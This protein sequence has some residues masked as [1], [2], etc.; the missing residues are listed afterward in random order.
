[1]SNSL[2]PDLQFIGPPLSEGPLPA[3][4]FFAISGRDS[5]HLDPFNQPV[6]HWKKFPIRIF[7]M[8]LPAHGPGEDKMEAMAA[9][10]EG[11]TRDPIGYFEPFFFRFG[12]VLEQL[13]GVIE[14]G[15]LA[16]AGISRGGFIATH[17]AA[18]YHQ[19]KAVLGYAPAVKL[20][21]LNGFPA[22]AERWDLE[23]LI[24]KLLN[25]KLKFYIGNR[26]IRVGTGPAFHFCQ[27]LAEQ[28]FK[29][30]ERSPQVEFSMFPSIG[31]KGHGTPPEVFL[32]GAEW[33][34]Q[35]LLN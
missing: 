12:V 17:L 31:H 11:L 28:K 16:V 3:I 26:D 1:M 6:S 21:E 7:S 13:S 8:D 9:W 2:A 30:G 34:R 25:V 32:E 10:S 19:I 27:Q 29:N 24:P 33:A 22:E 18:R 15:R 20:M 5:L 4:F 14:P 35:A 23:H